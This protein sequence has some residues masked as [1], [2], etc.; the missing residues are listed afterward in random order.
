MKRILLYSLAALALLASACGKDDK[1]G[2]LA[3]VIGTWY[4]QLETGADIWVLTDDS[5]FTK[6]EYMCKFEGTFTLQDGTLTLTNSKR[7]ERDY[8]RDNMSNPVLDKNGN[9]QYTDWEETDVD[10]TPEIYKVKMLYEGD[11]MILEQSRDEETYHI[12]F[13][14]EGASR[15]SNINDIQGKWHWAMFNNP[16]AIRALVKVEGNKAT[17]IIT[18]WGERYIGTITYEKGLVHMANP[19][20]TTSRWND[21][22]TGIWDHINDA[23]PENS[24]W[25]TPTMENGGSFGSFEYL[26]FPFI[27]DGKTAYATVANLMATFA[28]Q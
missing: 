7:W 20:F 1:P 8:V 17:V 3:D 26:V 16:Q 25:R 14:R 5:K 18:P 12:P 24:Q 21:E 10:K 4:L 22:E 2:S 6:T 27:V 9:Y 13:I 28:K 11:A 23:D 15:L 19:T